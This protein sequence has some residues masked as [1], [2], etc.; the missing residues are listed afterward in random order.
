MRAWSAAYIIIGLAMLPQVYWAALFLVATLLPLLAVGVWPI[1]S[2]VESALFL[3][4]IAVVVAA[5]L[6]LLSGVLFGCISRSDVA[7]VLAVT[8]AALYWIFVAGRSLATYSLGGHL[9]RFFYVQS[10][11]IGLSATI[12]AVQIL[13][14]RIVSRDSRGSSPPAS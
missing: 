5:F 12:G 4:S 2:A 13:S 14:A 11:L 7:I 10:L 6:S 1:R 3:A 8:A 9:S